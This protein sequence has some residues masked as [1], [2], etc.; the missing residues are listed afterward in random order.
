LKQFIFIATL[1][2]IAGLSILII[3]VK[4]KNASTTT[5][6]LNNSN[7]CGT[8]AFYNEN[9]SE[10]KKLFNANCASC[11]QLDRKMTGP[12]LR[13]V[14]QKY[15]SITILKFLHGEKTEIM[16]ED[17]GMTCVNFPQL[18]QEDISSL[19]SYTN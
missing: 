18:T 16:N 2:I 12:A 3:A 15:D 7:F 5:S 14:A 6:A 4:P 19:L 9:S 1:I 11:H 17:Y 8:N 13:N 10:G